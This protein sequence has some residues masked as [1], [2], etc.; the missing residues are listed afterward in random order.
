MDA[1]DLIIVALAV[2]AAIGGY[3]LGFLAR[4]VSW[5]GLA[6]GIVIAARAL[7]TI[8]NSFQGSDPTGKLLVAALVLLGGAFLGQAI[9]LLIG[10]KIHHFIPLGPLRAVDDAI[11]AGVGLLGVLVAVWLLIPSMGSV[12]GWPS[13]QARNSRIARLVDRN[14]PQPPDTMQTLRRLVGNEGFPLVFS[15]LVPAQDT[16]PPPADSGIPAALQARI[17]LSTVKVEGEACRR[18]QEGSGWTVG[19]GL[20]LTNAH[21]VAGE[22]HTVIRLPNS[23]GTTLPARVVSFDAGRDLALLSVPTLG[24]AP[25]P[26]LNA[27][28]TA[29]AQQHLVG[30]QGAVFG[31]P[32]GQD[33]LK[34]TP[35]LVRQYVSALGRDLYDAHDTKRDVF[36]LASDLMPGDSGGAL[37]D[38]TG[39]VIGVAFAIAPDRP[40]TSYALSYTEVNAF[41]AVPPTASASTGPCLRD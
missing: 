10:M 1:L 2:S 22:A 19:R 5:I 9:G 29:A 20:V 40:G 35:A 11:G 38:T 27:P 13:R 33:P 36:I 25:L 7:P 41:L 6:V 30:D 17:S 39:T 31:H 32:G 12:P 15:A 4:V 16:G 37:V 3:R 14:F 8:V 34:I 26:L 24:E 23:R 28:R 18:I 21:V